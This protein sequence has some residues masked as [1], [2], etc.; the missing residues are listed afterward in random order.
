LKTGLEEGYDFAQC[1]DSI[2]NRNARPHVVDIG[3]Q[4]EAQQE[5]AASNLDE[6]QLY[7]ISLSKESSHPEASSPAHSS[8]Q[9]RRLLGACDLIFT[10]GSK[11]VLCFDLIPKDS[12][13]VRVAAITSSIETDSFDFRHIVSQPDRMRQEDYWLQTIDGLSR[14]PAGNHS[15]NEIRILP[16]PP[17]MQIE[18]PGLQKEYLTDETAT[19]EVEITNDEDDDA[20]VTLEARF[21]GQADTV[22]TLSW[23]PDATGPGMTEDPLTDRRKKH[24]PST[25]LGHIEQSGMRK[26]HITFVAGPQATEAVLEIKALY[27][28]TAEPDTPVTKLLVHEIVFDRPFEAN[29]DFQPSIDPQP[30]PNYFHIAETN[31]PDNTAQGLRQLWT[32]T[33]RLA[34]VAPGPLIIEDVTL[35]LNG[36][37]DAAIC[38]I[39][40]DPTTSQAPTI[41]P[42]RFHESRFDILT[43]KLDVDD[44]RS[45]TFTF[46]LQIRWR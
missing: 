18:I 33:I 35:H 45:T 3:I 31:D 37:H 15:S 39:S 9:L 5:S 34:S 43:Q 26:I 19:L 32:S 2:P 14:T 44:R 23:T 24:I 7:D 8:P 16:K 25:Q 6:T 11:K 17:K 4:H 20:E 10:P 30:I 46:H 40:T 38:T 27:H 1:L 21:L 42:N 28:L 41:A 13:I 12:G 29:Y 36:I 22:P